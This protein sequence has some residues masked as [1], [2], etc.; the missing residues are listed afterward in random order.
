MILLTILFEV[1]RRNG[2]ETTCVC[3]TVSMYMIEQRVVRTGKD[4][5]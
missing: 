5:H 3:G 4:V 1:L 2:I